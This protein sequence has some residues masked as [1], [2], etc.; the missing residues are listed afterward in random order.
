MKTMPEHL[1][2]QIPLANTTKLDQKNAQN[3]KLFKLT[4]KKACETK[5]LFDQTV[6]MSKIMY[7]TVGLQM[8][9]NSRNLVKR[10]GP[11]KNDTPIQI[12][13]S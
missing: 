5:K 3:S 1:R 11:R 12:C 9:L 2:E 10:A 13:F 8:A 4:S 7:V 6:I